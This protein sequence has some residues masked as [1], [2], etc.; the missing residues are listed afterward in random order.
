MV[1][2]GS[3]KCSKCGIISKEDYSLTFHRFPLP[4]KYGSLKA[5]VWAKFCFPDGDWTSDESLEKLNAQHRMLCGHHFD[6]S[7]FTS[8]DRKRLNKFAIPS[9]AQSLLSQLRDEQYSPSRASHDIQEPSS[10]K[11]ILMV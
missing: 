10:L 11:S 5:K 2:K 9:G 1:G 3:V 6:D 4:S 8:S 7:S